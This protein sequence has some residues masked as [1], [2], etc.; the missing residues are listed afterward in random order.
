MSTVEKHSKRISFWLRHQPS[1]AGL[2][3]DPF[4]WVNLDDLLAALARLGPVEEAD[5]I[6]ATQQAGKVRWE[7]DSVGRRI[8][9]TH[10]HSFSIMQDREPSVPPPVLYHGTAAQSVEAILQ[11]GIRSM[12]RQ[13]VHL[14]STPAAALQ[15]GGR[16]GKPVLLRVHTEPLVA[17]GQLFYQTGDTVWL[18]DAVEADAIERG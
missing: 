2:V 8:R 16:H 17:K 5:L 18:T 6:A 7:I 14:S 1:D 13:F 4:G 9:A 12:Q 3:P 11:E 15:V 10:G